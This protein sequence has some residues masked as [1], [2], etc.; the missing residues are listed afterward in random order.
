[1]LFLERK[2]RE[3]EKQF[4]DGWSRRIIEQDGYGNKRGHRE[5]RTTGEIIASEADETYG[6]SSQKNIY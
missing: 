3:G 5:P 4:E 2:Y 1:M 6:S